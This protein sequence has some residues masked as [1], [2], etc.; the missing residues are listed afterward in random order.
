M[1]QKNSFISMLEQIAVLNKNSVEIISKL[2]D[3]V[4][5]KDN[6]ITVNYLSNDGSSKTYELPSVGFLKQEIDLANANIE[7]LS[8]LNSNDSVVIT[9]ESSSHKLKS[10]DLN[11]EPE[12]ISSVDLVSTFNQDNNWFFESLINPLLSVEI[13]LEDKIDA[14]VKKILSRRYIV[15]FEKDANGVLTTAG[16]SSKQQFEDQF[17]Y[18]NNITIKDFEKW[19]Y[20]STNTGV[21]RDDE[22]QFIDEQLFDTNYKEVDYKGFLS[23]LKQEKD[24]QNNKLWYH[25]NTLNYYDRDGNVR[26][27][28]IGDILGTTRKNSYSTWKIIEVNTSSSNFRLNLERV[29]GYE[30]VA[31]GTNVLQLISPLTARSKIKVSIGFDEYNVIF[32]KA[33]NTETNIISFEWSNGMSFYTNDLNLSTDTNV[34]MSDFYLNKVYDYGAILK[35]LVVKNIPSKFGTIPNKP[36]LDSD[37]FKVVQINKHATDTKDHKTLKKLHGQKNSIKAKINQINNAIV[38][39]NRELNVKQFNSVAERS[40]S[41]NELQELITKQQSETK[42]FSSYVSQITNSNI[43]VSAPP[44]FRIRGFWE[45]PDPIIKQG[46]KP[47]EV[48]GFD[49]QWRYGSKFGTQNITE[50]FE[51]KL[52]TYESSSTTENLSNFKKKTGYFSTWNNLK[53]DIRK[54]TF[55]EVTDEW[56]WI[57]EDISDADTPNINQLDIPIQKNEKVEIRVRSISEVGYPDAPIY[58]DWCDIMT[59]E[60]PDSLS[61]VL[62]DSEFILKEATQEEVKVQF[63]NELSSKGLNRHVLESYF[64]N[65]QYIAHNDK[66]I[67]TSFKDSFGNSLTLFEYL[68]QMTQKIKSLEEVILRAKGELK[69]TLFRGTQE[70]EVRNGAHLVTNIECEDYMETRKEIHSSTE[71]DIIIQNKIYMISDYYLKIENIANQNPLGILTDKKYN[72]AVTID[73]VS[74]LANPSIDDNGVISFQEDYQYLWYMKDGIDEN[75]DFQTLY[76]TAQTISV[77]IAVIQDYVNITQDPALSSDLNILDDDIWNKDISSDTNNPQYFAAS[78]HPKKTELVDNNNDNLH[79]IDAQEAN[80]IPLNLYFKPS[81]ADVSE[82]EFLVSDETVLRKKMLRIKLQAENSARAFDFSIT[83]NFKR[84]KQ[85]TTTGG[86][87]FF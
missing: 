77:E 65:E 5:S 49:I 20:L 21:K 2:S 84:H 66:V 44:K 79:L 74:S 61:D 31:I 24:T 47:Q 15:Q 60:F 43:E 70:T 27:L 87:A 34:N 26:I 75:G 17:L 18:K 63:E 41:H 6:N 11:R 29:E 52:K 55:N 10:I 78:V 57:I 7:K 39:K 86:Y 51:M 22:S 62:G 85:Y 13:D 67:N 32:L 25:V 54:R 71:I 82:I 38:E 50:G 33:I 1:S 19:L 59:I 64:E 4:G 12:Q 68:T 3:V 28:A 56:E 40:K 9:T 73:S 69:V 37:N 45:I 36:E 58:S 81:I 16:L 76:S 72:D 42:L 48:I 83:F 8:S 30:P 23:V 53:S 35:D 80:I 14:D 46:F